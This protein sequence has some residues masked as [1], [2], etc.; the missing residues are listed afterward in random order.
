MLTSERIDAIFESKDVK[1]AEW[2]ESWA[3]IDNCIVIY[4]DENPPHWLP[5]DRDDNG[6]TPEFVEQERRYHDGEAQA[7][8]GAPGER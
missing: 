3:K 8:S 4:D 5:K 2:G 7:A 6:N 1:N